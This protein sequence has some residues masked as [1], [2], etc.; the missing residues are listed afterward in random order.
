MKNYLII[1]TRCK[2]SGES[3]HMEFTVDFTAEKAEQLFNKIIHKYGFKH[4]SFEFTSFKTLRAPDNIDDK[5]VLCVH[6]IVDIIVDNFYDNT[7]EYSE[8]YKS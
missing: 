6:D 1:D 5:E 3:S 7:G 2:T 4:L 8:H